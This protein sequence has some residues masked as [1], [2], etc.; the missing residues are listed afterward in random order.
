MND[1]RTRV[2]VV[3]D[4]PSMASGIVRGLRAAGFD[5]ELATRGDDGA[6]LALA[7][8]PDA[9]VLD[10]LLPEQ[11]G[12][13]VLEAL[14]GRCVAPV[15]VLTARTEL[16]DRL[17]CFALGAA[18]FIGKPFFV[19][20]LVARIC[21]RLRLPEGAPRRAMKW[22]DV[23]IDL[24]GRTVHA[25]A[26]EANLTRNE[27][28]VLAYLVERPGRAIPRS[29]LAERTSLPTAERDA[30]TIDTHVARI[31]KKLGP[32]AA[33]AIVTVWGIGYRFDPPD[34]T[35]GPTS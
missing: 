19:E 14:Q 4:D 16:A 18:D 23:E 26:V 9:V 24:D 13:A 28:D 27:F 12:F 31:R 8:A 33:A 3:E 22:S 34:P 30:R 11:S 5:V 2:L 32:A 10:L 15:L 35:A 17:K 6:R 7:G 1:R 20:E 25:G 29:Q 21:S